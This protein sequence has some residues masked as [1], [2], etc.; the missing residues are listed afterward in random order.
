MGRHLD[1]WGPVDAYRHGKTRPR[2]ALEFLLEVPSEGL[3]AEARALFREY[4]SRDRTGVWTLAK[5]TYE[6]AD[7]VGSWRLAYHFHPV[8]GATSVAHAHCEPGAD[9]RGD[10]SPRHFR[11]VEYDLREA[12]AIFM[13]LYAQGRAPARDDLLPLAID[14]G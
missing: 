2:I 14:R 3:A 5:Y 4:F 13:R 11:S 7:I 9:L 12:N 8:D 6:Y 10:E 1:H